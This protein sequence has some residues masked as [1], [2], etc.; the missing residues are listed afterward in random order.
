MS[1]DRLIIPKPRSLED[2]QRTQQL[3]RSK[4]AHIVLDKRVNNWIDECVATADDNIVPIPYFDTR[5]W[6]WKVV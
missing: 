2:W 5:T 1:R 3:V 4:D 6:T